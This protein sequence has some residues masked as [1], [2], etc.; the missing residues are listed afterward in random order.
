MTDVSR[1]PNCP[2]ALPRRTL[3]LMAVTLT[4]CA[5]SAPDLRLSDDEKNEVTQI[6]QY[7]DGLKSFQANFF[8]TGAFGDGTGTVWLDRPGHLR[9]DYAGSHAKTLVANNGQLIVFDG[10]T[11]GTTTMPLSRTPL[12]MLLTPSI[13]LSGTVAVTAYRHRAGLC[14]LTIEKADAPNQGSLTLLLSPSPLTLREV[15]L[16]DAYERTLVMRLSDMHLNPR[17]TSDLFQL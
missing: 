13:R 10:A 6:G 16:T 2:K 7:L 14:E 3:I 8:Q 17:L 11:S 4:A 9:M 15:L 12:S 5:T 1:I